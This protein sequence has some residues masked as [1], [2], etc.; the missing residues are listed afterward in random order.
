MAL[1]QRSRNVSA[2]G[3]FLLCVLAILFALGGCSGGGPSDRPPPAPDVVSLGWEPVSVKLFR[4]TWDDVAGA[5]EYRLFENP[6]GSSG[7]TQVASIAPGVQ[8]YDLAVFLPARVNA[9]YILSVC[10]ADGCTDSRTVF[11]SGNLA[12]AVGYVKASNTEA[13]D[14]FGYSVALSGDG[15]TLAVGTPREDSSATGIDGDQTDNSAIK[16]GAVYV[17]TR[18]GG[19]W[20]QQAYVKASNTSIH[21]EGPGYE[22]GDWFGYSVSLSGDGNTLA[23][24]AIGERS[25][26]TGI[27][28]DQADNSGWWTGAV[29]V[30]TR[31]DGVWSQQA[32]VKASNRAYD[33]FQESFGYSVSLSGDGNTLAVGAYG[34]SSGATGIDGDQTD[35]SALFSGAVY[36]FTRSDGV[37]S[38]QAYVKASNTGVRDNFG[39]SVSLSGDGTTLAVGAPNED[40]RATGINGNQ[41]DN[42]EFDSGA[43]YVFIRSGGVWSQQA[44]VKASN[45]EAWDEFGYSVALSGD[46][47]TLAV[48][49]PFEDS[50]ATGI[51]GNQANNSAEDSGAVYVFTRSGGVWSQQAYVKASNTD[52]HDWFG[53]SVALSG[54]GNTLVAGAPRESRRAVG[55]DGDQADNPAW[56]TG[57]AYVFTRSGGVWRQQAYVKA[58]NTKWG[59][60]FGYSAALSGDGTTLAVGAPGE[61]SNATGIGGGQANSSEP[62][63]GAVYLF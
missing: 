51:N 57:A 27:D 50:S 39:Y 3:V 53:T 7:F 4:F 29:Y 6:D 19:V 60:Y 16:S 11:V 32:Y 14:H 55:I 28:G 36:V 56:Y 25:I 13:G 18:S 9:R 34:E 40:S 26:A 47:N 33:W 45:T 52:E 30:F 63:S 1:I 17:F 61:S 41:A 37:W 31:S 54:D 5:T 38:Q 22:V 10:N 49:A 59:Q 15:T 42:S 44:Y 21:D 48:G 46:G 43:V 58:S 8:S 12:R 20:R 2:G 62:G 35:S 24:G 23:V